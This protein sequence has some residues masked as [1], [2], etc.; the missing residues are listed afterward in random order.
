MTWYLDGFNL[1]TLATN[2]K[3]RSAGWS[4]PGKIGDNIRVPGRH[5]AFFTEGKTYDEGDLTLS[6]WAAGCN[7]DGTLPLEDDAKKKVRDNLDKLTSLFTPSNRLLNLRQITGTEVALINE[8]TNPGMTSATSTGYPLAHNAIINGDKSQNTSREVSRNV[9]TNPYLK[10]QNSDEYVISEDLNPDPIGTMHASDPKQYMLRGYYYP[11]QQNMSF[12]SP[13]FSPVNSFY[14][15]TTATGGEIYRATAASLSA[16]SWVGYWSRFVESDRSSGTSFFLRARIASNVSLTSLNVYVKPYISY[17]NTTWVAGTSVQGTLTKDYSNIIVPVTS[18]PAMSAGAGFYVRYD[19]GIS[20]SFNWPV[21][22]SFDISQVAWQ[23]GPVA[24]NPWRGYETFEHVIIGDSVPGA[25]YASSARRSWSVFNEEPAPE[26]KPLITSS[27]STTAPYAFAFHRWNTQDQ[28]NKM[29]FSVF[30]GTTQTFERELAVPEFSFND[31][32]IWGTCTRNSSTAS[33]MS[34]HLREGTEGSYTYTQVASVSINSKVF[35]SSK[36]SVV[37]GKQYV[38]RLEVPRGSQGLIPSITFD[39]IHV[40]NG[41]AKTF[42]YSKNSAQSWGDSARTYQDILFKS[43]IKAVV[44]KPYAVSVGTTAPT[45]KNISQGG[46]NWSKEPGQVFS[47]DGTIKLDRVVLPTNIQTLTSRIALQ[48]QSPWHLAF[49]GVDQSTTATVTYKFL[50]YDS[51]VLRTTTQNITGVTSQKKYFTYSVATQPGEILLDITIAHPMPSP[52][53]SDMLSEAYIISNLPASVSYFAGDAVESSQ[54][55]TKTT[56]W[57]GVPLFSQSMLLASLPRGWNVSG[58]DGFSPTDKGAM[59]FKSGHVRVAI[60]TA[61]NKVYVGFKRGPYGSDM[62]IS[63]Q[64]EGAASPTVLGTLTSTKDFVMGFVNLPNNCNYIDFFTTA[65]ANNS[66]KEIFVIDTYETIYPIP[67]TSWVGFNTDSSITLSLP[68]HPSSLFP[69]TKVTK[70]L[71]DLTMSY[72]T[73]EVAGWNGSVLSGGYIPSPLPGESRTVTSAPSPVSKGYVSAAARVQPSAGA[74]GKI[75][76]AIQAATE[77]GI[78]TNT[79]TTL[80]ST[81]VSSASYTEVKVVDGVVGPNNKWVRLAITCDNSASTFQAGTVMAIIDG[82]TLC[83][84][85]YPLGSNFPGYFVGAKS[86]TGQTTYR[87]NIRECWVEVVDSIDMD[88]MAYGTIAEFN[89]GMRVP[90]S[91]WSDVYDTTANLVAPT[92]TTSGNFYVTDFGGAT[93]PMDD[94][95][96]EITPVSGT[97]TKFTLSDKGSGNYISFNGTAQSRVVINASTASVLSN[98]GESIVKFVDSI[99]TNA[100]MSMTPYNRAPGETLPNHSDGTP[101][102][103]WSANVPIR[104]SISGRRKYLIG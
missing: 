76:V 77:D 66:V 7:E 43:S 88:S 72:E 78:L 11:I 68:T 92:G 96:Y 21:G 12:N 45:S 54:T 49:L 2:V 35:S 15:R 64:P 99:G 51:N 28:W 90:G 101:V 6:M 3:S 89:V 32:K 33:T 23:D 27:R 44:R 40:S 95:V 59:V 24:G 71:M 67:N 84:S 17:D 13:F 81:T 18:L 30:G 79:W 69:M 56:A 93:A 55:W 20:P 60:T 1:S 16:D 57:D 47:V 52:L 73:G 86:S 10:G 82:T 62:P 83:P 80:K 8:I 38:L 100:I 9:F 31:V 25:S 97:L 34:I 87:G 37:A 36:F 19:L 53:S 41:W 14:N 63:A 58:F 103:S 39:Y 5:G 48:F 70:N 4:I 61:S 102:L 104:V 75:T 29:C 50:D 85:P 94:L 91:F 26:W 98:T 46:V 74:A 22:K 42:M 65:Q